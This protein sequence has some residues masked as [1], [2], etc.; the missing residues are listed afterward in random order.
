MKSFLKLFLAVLLLLTATFGLQ[1]LV[2]AGARHAGL[3]VLS[4][5]STLPPPPGMAVVND[6]STLPP[7][8]GLRLSH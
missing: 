7:P 4:D 8:P 3:A 5:G 6:G 1:N 2:R